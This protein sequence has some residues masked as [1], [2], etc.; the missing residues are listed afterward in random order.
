MRTVSRGDK[1]VCFGGPQYALS[2]A[3]MPHPPD[4]A[5][6]L[7]RDNFPALH[8][9]PSKLEIIHCIDQASE[10]SKIL[11]VKIH[12]EPRKMADFRIVLLPGQ[13]V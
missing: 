13:G 3:C 2:T 8:L 4:S 5:I 11:A 9:Y 6:I 12:D 1:Y 7:S 10:P